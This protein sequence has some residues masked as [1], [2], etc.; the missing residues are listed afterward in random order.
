MRRLSPILALVLAVLLVLNVQVKPAKAVVPAIP[1]AVVGVTFLGALGE[2]ALGKVADRV[3]LIA[4]AEWRLA[5]A[6]RT[7]LNRGIAVAR[8]TPNGWLKAGITASV[9]AA[10]GIGVIASH[11]SRKPIID[12]QLPNIPHFQPGIVQFIP[13]PKWDGSYWEPV[14]EL[15]PPMTVPPSDS[16]VKTFSGIPVALVGIAPDFGGRMVLK[17]NMGTDGCGGP[18]YNFKLSDAANMAGTTL[19]GNNGPHWNWAGDGDIPPEPGQEG[20]QQYVDVQEMW[21]GANKGAPVRYTFVMPR[22]AKE[23]QYAPALSPG[24][25]SQ[26]HGDLVGELAP[27][28]G[29]IVPDD[30]PT[31]Y[32]LNPDDPNS[33]MGLSPNGELPDLE[34]TPAPPVTPTFTLLDSTAVKSTIA[35][36]GVGSYV[37]EGAPADGL[38][39]FVDGTVLVGVDVLKPAGT[40]TIQVGNT[41]ERQVTVMPYSYG[42]KKYGPAIGSVTI[43]RP[44]VE[45]Q[46]TTAPSTAPSSSPT[47]APNP[48]P[49]PVTDPGASPA[50]NPLPSTNPQ[51]SPEPS[52]EPPIETPGLDLDRPFFVSAFLDGMKNKFPFDLLNDRVTYTDPP[53]EYEMWGAKQN[54]DWI[55]PMFVALEGIAMVGMVWMAILM[56]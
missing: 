45:P 41:V 30:A 20:R 21:C 38:R 1:W 50:P 39:F 33:E 24:T 43:T 16:Q 54:F 18:R 19:L 10:V 14:A 22:N 56:L 35:W 46:P 36:G 17:G 12:P 52:G 53:L 3:G 7:T 2:V 25:N 27:A 13:K 8:K 55:K 26:L 51:P 4:E 34:P 29:G 28:P 6:Q 48:L 11:L 32:P 44:T 5:P 9:L 49:S 42:N 37:I 23:P 31:I 40:I 15:P 47:T